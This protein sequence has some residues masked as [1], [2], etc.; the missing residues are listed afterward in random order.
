MIYLTFCLENLCHVGRDSYA[1]NPKIPNSWKCDS[2]AN[3]PKIPNN[4]LILH[5]HPR[6]FQFSNVGMNTKSEVV[7][8]D[9]LAEVQVRILRKLNKLTASTSTNPVILCIIASCSGKWCMN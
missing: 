7:F 8:E 4:L 5:P 9:I 2:Y 1:N 3:N 6:A